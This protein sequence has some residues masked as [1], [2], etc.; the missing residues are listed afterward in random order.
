MSTYRIVVDLSERR[1]Y[2]YEG[3]KITKSY[4]IGVGRMLSKTPQGEFMIV[5]K[6]TDPGGPYGA[7]WMGLSK[8]HYGIHGTN[9]PSTI[10]KRVSRG[11]IR[12]HNKDVL[13][14]SKLV[15]IG[16]HVTIRK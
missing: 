15:P 5:N 4:P 12:M 2:L 13:E 1:L 11:C 16:T 7:M 8:K 14:L 6:E 10:G 3:N 9:R